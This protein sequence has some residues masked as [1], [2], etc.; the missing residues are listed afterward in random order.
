MRVKSTAHPR[1]LALCAGSGLE[2]VRLAK[3]ED[4]ARKS[5]II[6]K[7]GKEIEE[8]DKCLKLLKKN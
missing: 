1:L 5:L 4:S 7:D 8:V 2:K 3:K 6:T